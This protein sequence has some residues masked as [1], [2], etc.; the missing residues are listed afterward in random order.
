MKLLLLGILLLVP[1]ALGLFL[2]FTRG[3]DS[4]FVY[5]AAGLLYAGLGLTLYASVIPWT[6][7]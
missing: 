2:L 6:D 3:S 5:L 1:G 4:Y 7:D